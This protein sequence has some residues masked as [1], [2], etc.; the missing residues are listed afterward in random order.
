MF[1]PR[2][3]QRQRHE[4]QIC[5]C[6]GEWRDNS[7]LSFAKSGLPMNIEADANFRSILDTKNASN[8]LEYLDARFF[9]RVIYI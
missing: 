5:A 1:G 8:R 6:R 9:H 2:K 4:Q 3:N 7:I